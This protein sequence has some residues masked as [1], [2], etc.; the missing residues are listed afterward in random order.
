M[1]VHG[2]YLTDAR[3]RREAECLVKEGFEVHAICVRGALGPNTSLEPSHEMVNGVHIHRVP[4][5][6]KRGGKLRYAFEYVALTLLGAWK[7][8]LLSLEKRFDVIHIHNMPDFMVLAGLIPKWMGAVVILDIHDPMSEMFQAKYDLRESHLL[9]RVLKLQEWM[10]Y[11][12]ADHLLTV[13]IPMAEN[14]AKKR[15]CS[16]D[17]V[18]IVHNFPDGSR[19]PIRVDRDGWPYNKDEIIFLFSGTV[20][21]HYRLDIAVR[22]LA[23]VSQSIPNISFWILGGGNRLDEVLV[24]AKELRIGEKVKHIPPV[25]QAE[26]QNIMGNVDMGITTHESGGFGDLYFSTKIIEFMTQGLPVISSRTSTIE[27]Y[28]PKDAIFY[29]E[30]EEVEGLVKAIIFVIKNPSIVQEKIRNSRKILSEFTWQEEQKKLLSFYE[31]LTRT[32]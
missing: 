20:S 18:K 23:I 2:H 31:Q 19:F 24:L 8:L 5:E 9:I 1:L 16:V 3:V 26:V 32:R 29:F 25:D 30:P 10:C 12:L 4:L 6:K 22:A 13:S 17:A 27:K 11:R 28:I 14:V 21:E 7:L 15:G